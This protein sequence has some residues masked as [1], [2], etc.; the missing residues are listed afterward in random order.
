MGWIGLSSVEVSGGVIASA[1]GQAAIAALAGV[2]LV[3]YRQ[4]MLW[5]HASAFYTVLLGLLALTALG[6]AIVFR[7]AKLFEFVAGS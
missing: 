1:G 5:L 3:L 7:G 4:L 2:L 6:A